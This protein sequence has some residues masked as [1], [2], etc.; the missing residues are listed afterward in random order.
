[1]IMMIILI[2]FVNNYIIFFTQAA[3]VVLSN[4]LHPTDFFHS[5]QGHVSHHCY[6]VKLLIIIY[7]NSS[8]Y[9]LQYIRVP[10][11]SRPIC[12]SSSQWGSSLRCF[13]LLLISTSWG[14]SNTRNIILKGCLTYSVR[15]KR[16][17]DDASITIIQWLFWLWW[18]FDAILRLCFWW[19]WSDWWKGWGFLF[20]HFKNISWSEF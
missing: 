2:I 15:C 4:W 20:E 7:I 19:T 9:L 12:S 5:E 10:S 17:Y 13:F 1:M 8:I 14:F 6:N 18:C 16:E 11:G 3:M